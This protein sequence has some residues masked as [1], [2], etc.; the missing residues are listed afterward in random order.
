MPRDYKYRVNQKEQ[1]R[2]APAWIWMLAGLLIGA[3][4]MGLVWLKLDD[5]PSD[6]RWVG[7]PPDRAPQGDDEVEEVVEVPPHKPRFDFWDQL[8]RQEVVVPEEQ[9]DLR[10]DPAVSDATSQYLIQAGSFT[11]STDAERARAEMAL[12]GIETKVSE[13]R[14]ANGRV[15]Y[16]VVAGPYLGR[17]A[18]D[19]A[20]ARLRDNGYRQLLVRIIK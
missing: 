15:A 12:L 18:L 3:F 17:S 5:K 19:R 6:E 16:R 4:V 13:A 9:L 10:D 14:L 20:R 8:K 2:G 7:A 1:L 11:K